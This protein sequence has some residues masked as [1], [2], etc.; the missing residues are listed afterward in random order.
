MDKK[1]IVC[2]LLVAVAIGCALFIKSASNKSYL[3]LKSGGSIEVDD[4]W[5]DGDAVLYEKNGEVLVIEKQEAWNIL[6]GPLEGPKDLILR[7]YYHTI[8]RI[9]V[10]GIHALPWLKNA[11]GQA[12]F[13]ITVVLSA[14]VCW[15]GLFAFKRG[16]KKDNTSIAPTAVTVTDPAGPGFRLAGISDIEEFFLTMYKLQLDAPLNAP[17]KIVRTPG[18][19]SGAGHVYTLSVKIKGEWKSRAVTIG[20]LGE[21]TGSKSQCFYVIFDTHMVVKIPAE[22]IRDFSDYIQRV[23]YEGQIVGKLSPRE[24]IIPSISVILNKIISLPGTHNLPADQLEEKYIAFLGSSPRYQRYLKIGGE[25]AFFMN[26][27]KYY[28][29]SHVMDSLHKIKDQILSTIT[30]DAGLILDCQEFGNKYGSKNIWVCFELQKLFSLFDTGIKKLAAQ[31]GALVTADDGQKKDW[32][33]SHLAWQDISTQQRS[34]PGQLLSGIDVLLQ[35]LMTKESKTV[36]AYRKLAK[37]YAYHRS[38]NRNKP[39]IEGIITN[40]LALLAWLGKNNVAMR[41]LK[42]DNLLVAGDPENYPLFLSSAREYA[43]GL[44][45]LETAVDYN[46][47]KNRDPEQPQL[48]GTPAYAT[49]SHF[50]QNEIL[51]EMHQDLP[52]IL[53]TQD[54]HAITCIIYEVVTGKRLFERT[55]GQIAALVRHIQQDSP[56]ESTLP[57]TYKKVSRMFWKSAIAE[58]EAKTSENERR[59]NSMDV[60]VPESMKRQFEAHLQK[61]RDKDQKEIPVV[62]VKP[63]ARSVDSEE[64]LSKTDKRSEHLLKLI[65]LVD[66]PRARIPVKDLIELMFNLVLNTMYPAGWTALSEGN[67]Q[68][69]TDGPFYSE[70]G[71]QDATLGYTVTVLSP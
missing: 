26:L 14:T 42:P 36:T 22:P 64:D 68:S 53:N 69:E 47:T 21:T 55:A 19:R 35:K 71:N 66:N 43:I 25:F 7:I 70:G 28:F 16:K 44:I 6:V 23:R 67:S 30:A 38:Y 8:D 46:P 3:I 60:F 61:K 58:F 17:A 33:F 1:L 65:A 13:W 24:C 32:M 49:P 29:L 31:S 56:E 15:A 12:G 34:I 10:M 57:S 18:Q 5:A 9:T 45:D 40:L 27:S 41:D 37:G 48:G 52:L 50:F 63:S 2:L 11:A 54:W 62:P 59:L 20:P 51:H 39:V 4:A